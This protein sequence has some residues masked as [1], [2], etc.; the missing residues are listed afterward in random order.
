MVEDAEMWVIVI[1]GSAKH[2]VVYMYMS[3][4]SVYQIPKGTT[5]SMPLCDHE[6][7]HEVKCALPVVLHDNFNYDAK[8]GPCADDIGKRSLTNDAVFLHEHHMIQEKTLYGVYLPI[9]II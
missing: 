2:R 8:T 9:E 5:T 4:A 1:A 7:A 3:G 6:W